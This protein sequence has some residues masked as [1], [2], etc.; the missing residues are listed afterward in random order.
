MAGPLAGLKELQYIT[1]IGGNAGAGEDEPPVDEAAVAAAWARACP[2]L[3]TIVLPQG[4]VWFRKDDR[5]RCMDG[6]GA[7]SAPAPGE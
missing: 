7:C 6:E 4:K 3:K 2:T 5:W 1:L